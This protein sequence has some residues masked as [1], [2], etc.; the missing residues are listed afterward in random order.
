MSKVVECGELIDASTAISMSVLVTWCAID[1]AFSISP[2]TVE[3]ALFS[4]SSNLIGF[5]FQRI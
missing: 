5:A 4:I 1:A 3:N 2:L